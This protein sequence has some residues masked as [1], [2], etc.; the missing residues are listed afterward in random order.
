MIYKIL[1]SAIF[2][3]TFALDA[4]AQLDRRIGGPRYDVPKNKKQEKPDYTAM[5]VSKLKEDL[6]LDNF[7]EAVITRLLTENQTKV[8][9]VMAEDIPQDSKGEK[10]R[11]L[12]DQVRSEIRDI[13]TP[14]QIVKFE[15]IGKKKKK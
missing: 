4:N 5:T 11:E 10:L 1:I 12:N 8:E 15:S 13:L 9:K 14:E 7:Q 6:S 2:I 3:F